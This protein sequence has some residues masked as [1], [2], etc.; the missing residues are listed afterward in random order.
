MVSNRKKILFLSAWYP[1]PATNGSKL[2]IFNI[3][4]QLVVYYDVNLITF[5]DR[6]GQSEHPPELMSICRS[7]Q[8]VPIISFHPNR[9]RARL[10]FLS[11]V[12][13]SIID[14]HSAPMEACIQNA[15][16]SDRPDV[17]IASQIDT[18]AYR[19][20]FLGVPAIFEEVEIGLLSDRYR[21]ETNRFKK[22]KLWF[23]I[24]KQ[25]KYLGTL[26]R[27]YQG[28]TVVS[29][30]EK[31]RLLALH[32]RLP[33]ITVIPNCVA[34]GDY[35]SV[36][37][38]PER[39]TMI[40]TGAFNYSP[41]YEA[42]VWFLERIF[43]LILKEIP[44]ARLTITGDHLDLPLPPYPQVKRT[45]YLQDVRPEVANAW[46]SIAPLI[47]GG[48]TRLKILEAMALHTPVVSTMKGAE[49]LNVMHGKDILL[50]D[51]PE[52]FSS[53]IIS[54]CKDE[55][56]RRRLSENAFRLIE[57]RYEW[58]STIHGLLDQIERIAL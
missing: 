49:G 28:C 42:M 11:P 41:N 53:A 19:K 24:A 36:K 15:I 50:A 6:P 38:T 51:Q 12:P 30:I 10:G 3:L 57:E 47:S 39:Y 4:R 20:S 21:D 16:Q 18:A 8:E 34:L 33:N 23:T 5:S 9:L 27:S 52:G 25:K 48:G 35:R 29:E 17:V 54:L 2:R 14:T 26:L 7:I 55:E 44:N 46:I 56:L 45:G 40:F 13:R 43:P 58:S 31:Q 32:P 1:Y 37:K 22:Q